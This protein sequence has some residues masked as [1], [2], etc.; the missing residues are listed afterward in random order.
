MG[1]SQ[2]SRFTQQAVTLAQNGVGGRDEFAA[3]GRLHRR[4]V[5]Q[6]LFS[7]LRPPC[8]R[9]C[10]QSMILS[11]TA[12]R[13]CGPSARRP[14]ESPLAS[15]EALRVRAS[16]G[17]SQHPLC[18][19]PSDASDQLP[20]GESHRPPRKSHELRL[21]P[22]T[23]TSAA[24]DRLIRT[25]EVKKRSHGVVIPFTVPIASW[26]PTQI[27]LVQETVFRGIVQQR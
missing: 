25:V 10:A 1:L 9:C 2:V 12:T 13:C 17:R 26:K 23:Q 27:W 5:A 21:P 8:E 7:V 16:I 15:T 20:S 6:N 4:S 22:H 3:L 18:P 14:P 11:S 24:R 19:S